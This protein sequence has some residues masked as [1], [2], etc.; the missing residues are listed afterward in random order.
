LAGSAQPSRQVILINLEPP[1][2][3]VHH[4]NHKQHKRK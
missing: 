2:V 3:S 4:K 1:P